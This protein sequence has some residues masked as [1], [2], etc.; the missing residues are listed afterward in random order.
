MPKILIIDNEE[1]TGEDTLREV[2]LVWPE[3]R[4]VLEQRVDEAVVAVRDFLR[5]ERFDAIVLDIGFTNDLYGGIQ[6]Y[7][8]IAAGATLRGRWD[9][10]IIYTKHASPNVADASSESG[11]FPI[12]VFVETA[13]IPVSNIVQSTRGGRGPLIEK[14]R[15][16][17]T[18]RVE[19]CRNCGAVREG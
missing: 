16:L 18:S 10:T 11:V 5:A 15:Q 9:H 13:G 19:R 17:L 4:L 1:K 12:R 3:S 14:I 8:R 2:Q 6:L 7:N